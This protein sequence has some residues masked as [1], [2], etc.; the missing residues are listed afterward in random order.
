MTILRRSPARGLRLAG[1]VAVATAACMAYQPDL[2]A[3]QVS[4]VR[5]TNDRCGGTTYRWSRRS[6]SAG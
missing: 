2:F 5:S 4:T 6:G 1:A 3:Q